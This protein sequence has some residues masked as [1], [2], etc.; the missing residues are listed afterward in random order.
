MGR[1]YGGSQRT[2]AW[3]TTT[4]IWTWLM[5][6][7]GGAQIS[8]SGLKT[9][10]SGDGFLAENKRKKRTLLT[11]IIQAFPRQAVIVWGRANKQNFLFSIKIK[12]FAGHNSL[13]GGAT[14]ALCV[15]DTIYRLALASEALPSRDPGGGCK[16]SFSSRVM[17]HSEALSFPTAGFLLWAGSASYH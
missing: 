12:S 16:R 13:L 3:F 14:S 10:V 8:I 1:F 7:S 2:C 11:S 4:V 15:I 17:H 5:F 9:E 6:Y